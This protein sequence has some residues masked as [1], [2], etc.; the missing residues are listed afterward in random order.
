MLVAVNALRLPI[1]LA[2]KLVAVL[3]RQAAPIRGAVCALLV[4]NG[5]LVRFQI[6]G[7]P[8]GNLT[9][10]LALPDTRLLIA[11]T[12]INGVTLVIG[13]LREKRSGRQRHK[14]R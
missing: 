8:S 10:C 6:T 11:A 2:R 4:M 5:V 7:A 3:C 9:G 13:G 12:I 1:L 14:C